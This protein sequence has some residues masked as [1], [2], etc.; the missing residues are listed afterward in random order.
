MASI[1][2]IYPAGTR[3]HSANGGT[4]LHLDPAFVKHVV[5]FAQALLAEPSRTAR[6]QTTAVLHIIDLVPRSTEAIR[7]LAAQLASVIA[8]IHDGSLRYLF[9][10]RRSLARR[11][12][13]WVEV[14]SPTGGWR[15]NASAALALR[16]VPA[17]ITTPVLVIGNELVSTPPNRLL[18]AHYGKLLECRWNGNAPTD[19][20]W[21]ID[22]PPIEVAMLPKGMRAVLSDCV[23]Y[24]NSAPIP[25]P[26]QLLSRLVPLV[27]RHTGPLGIYLTG[28][29]FVDLKALRLAP[30]P[31]LLDSMQHGRSVL[32]NFYLLSQWLRQC[33]AATAIETRADGSQSMIAVARTAESPHLLLSKCRAELQ[34]ETQLSPDA[35][36]LAMRALRVGTSMSVRLALLRAS[37]NSPEVFA[38]V[39]PLIVHGLAAMSQQERAPWA[40][41]LAKVW[42]QWS[43]STDRRILSYLGQAAMLCHQW[44]VAAEIWSLMLEQ[45]SDHR[46]VC[47]R[48]LGHCYA[49]SGRYEAAVDALQA[50]L[51]ENDE[52][53]R[54]LIQALMTR[55]QR[56]PRRWVQQTG[57]P[58]SLEPLDTCHAEAFLYQFR[59]PQISVMT[60]LPQMTS[61]RA[62]GNWM[63]R[64]QDDPSR[65][66]WAVMHPWHGF[67]GHVSLATSEDVAFFCFW[68]GVDFQGEGYGPLAGQLALQYAF[69]VGIRTVITS[70]YADNERSISALHDLGFKAL[71]LHAANPD[72]LRRF[73]ARALS[74][75][76]E[77][78]PDIVVNYYRREKIPIRFHG[79]DTLTP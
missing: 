31:E 62:I 7:Q 72:H 74:T 10:C 4:G 61:R 33:G 38:S 26:E 6:N 9:P 14:L 42:Q 79:Y 40:H 58:L 65:T 47:W 15:N 50:A 77:I 57:V 71:A 55:R 49:R 34:E 70:V 78:S 13:D 69:D 25:Y 37:G 68:M 52:E 27:D 16:S 46:G 21:S 53:A 17:S 19:R 44:G 39:A 76:K 66:E 20:R 32:L 30:F 18:A 54:S 3:D 59:D 43:L 48:Q 35:W 56:W 36:C 2:Q 75:E 28:K 60:G 23:K 24:L 67:I 63:L 8:T 12:N 64:I 11:S 51:R 5:L 1:H 29:G 22:W 41:C 73:F 45:V